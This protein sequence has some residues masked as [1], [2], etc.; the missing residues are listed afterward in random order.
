MLVAVKSYMF[1]VTIKD[2]VSLDVN[3]LDKA[4]K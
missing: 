2:I 1:I 4:I 3:L